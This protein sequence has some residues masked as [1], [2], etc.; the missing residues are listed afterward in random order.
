[1]YVY[2]I[3][4]RRE[5]GSY[6]ASFTG[7]LIIAVVLLLLGLSF[8]DMVEKLHGDAVSTPITEQ[9]FVTLYFWMIFLLTTPVMT[10]RTFAL[11]RFS[12][13]YET[14]MTAAVKDW[15][16]VLGKFTGALAF[17]CLTWLPLVV[18]M[19][20]VRQ[21]TNEPEAL[22]LWT[23]SSTFL[24]LI[25][26]GAVYLS[27]GCFASALTRSQMVAAMLS[28]AFGV[29]LFLLSL[30]SLMARRPVGWVADTLGHISMPEH[31][32][33]FAR[34]VIDTRPLIFYVSVTIFFLFLTLKVVESRRWK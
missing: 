25:L 3:L 20:L 34:G 22:D 29:A 1:M 16:V 10:M 18:Y 27:L 8:S 13:T 6:F 33:D 28:Y 12:G 31:V 23:L 7:Y 19:I 30:G 14:L 9:F 17:F 15:E 26:I 24:G 21:Y 4:V 5:L 2:W 11:E 32:E